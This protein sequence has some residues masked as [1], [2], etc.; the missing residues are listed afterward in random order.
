MKIILSAIALF[1]CSAVLTAQQTDIVESLRKHVTI[2][3]SDSLAG[4]GFGF[5]EK[6]LAT[7]YITKQ[8]T[9][10]GFTAPFEGSYI[11]NFTHSLSFSLIEGKNIIG[12]IEGS[13]PELKDEYILLGAHYDHMGWKNEG[14]KKVVYNG[15][16]DNASG[17]AAII[18]IGKMLIND[19]G[20]LRRSVIIA[21]F[22]GEEAGLLG[23]ADFAL[24]QVP[25]RFDVKIMFSLDMVGMLGSNGGVNYSGF[26]SLT[27]GT[28][29]AAEVIRNFAMGVTKIDNFIENSTD[30]WHFAEKGVPSV[31]IYTGLKS[32]YHKPTDD[33]H[34][35]DID[36][37]SKIAEMMTGMTKRLSSEE[38]L[39]ANTRF[40]SRQVSPV[41]L[42]GIRV[43]V[44][45]AY[46]R[47]KSEYYSGWPVIAV[48][49]GPEAQLRLTKY[50]WLQP[51]VT[52]QL[53]GSRTDAGKLRTHSL[54]PQCNLLISNGNR[55]ISHTA[56][57][58]SVGGYYSHAF[59]GR[60]GKLSAD[61]LTRFNKTDY[62][63]N[64]GGGIAI[65]KTQM[66]FAYRHGL[67]KVYSD[68]ASGEI[69]TRGFMISTTRYF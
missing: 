52:Y 57:F 50:L 36:G 47:Y 43:G 7:D 61:F 60:E 23:S 46:H 59:A 68:P 21:A 9:E 51:A 44:G 56:L 49:A 16:D 31:H 3:A 25:D 35:L 27:G 22:D 15:A 8:Y 65:I 28:E 5:P 6:H 30:T 34:L 48:E 45:W 69:A 1:F 17:V 10:A 18:E 63:L 13:D 32:P 54:V 58:F 66:T 19:R 38:E 29:L 42:A 4:R 14:G 26:R 40:I 64:V 41:V 24:T 12:I 39:K 37:I 11:H 20:S 2:L 67:A 55:N 62:G 53:A 33:S